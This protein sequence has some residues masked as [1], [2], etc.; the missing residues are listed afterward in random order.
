MYSLGD[1]REKKELSKHEGA[2]FDAKKAS[3][4]G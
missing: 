2:F 1:F 4:V 3:L